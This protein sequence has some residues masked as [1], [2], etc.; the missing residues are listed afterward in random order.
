MGCLF[1]LLFLLVLVVLVGVP[2]GAVLLGIDRAPLVERQ[3]KLSLGDLRQAQLLAQRYDP[4][5]MDPRKVT[6]VTATQNELNTLLRGALMGV[7]Q[8]AARVNVDRRGVLAGLTVELPVPRNPVGRYV[9][10]RIAIAPSQ[11]GLAVTRLAAG[12][13]EIPPFLVRPALRLI[14]DRLTGPGKG[15]PIVASVRSVR[16]AAPVVTVAFQPPPALVEDLKKAAMRQVRVSHP[17]TV[18]VYYETLAR[19][20][21]RSTGRGRVSLADFVREAFRLARERSE[22]HDAV[23][24]NEA[25]VIALAMMFGD[26]RFEKF[27]GEVLSP[28]ERRQW[29]AREQVRL[30]GRHDFV[31]HFAISAGL[32]LTGGAAAADIIGELKEVKDSGHRS[33]FSF[34]DIGADRM[35]VR[36]ARRSTGDRATAIRFQNTL[37]AL[38]DERG[39]FP[40]LADLPEGMSEAEFRRR[41]GDVGSPAYERMVGEIDRRID[42]IPLYR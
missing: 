41:F 8:A 20:A 2:G 12:R 28:A 5:R 23:R 9:N 31:Q 11:Q 16:I 36:F 13:I 21:G 3:G 7:R 39:F 37:A 1:R 19:A 35:G 33:G 34:T 25:A 22:T 4:R 6:A 27:V 29:R 14:L 18:R 24:E 26:P 32:A 30:N 40:H 10:I 15:E 17:R 38:R 42:A